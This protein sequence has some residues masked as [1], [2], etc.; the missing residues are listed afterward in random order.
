[1]DGRSFAAE[2]SAGRQP[3][4][5][6]IFAEIASDAAIYKGQFVP[7]QF[8]AHIMVRNE[9]WKYV[10]NRY[11]AGEL[12]HL[13]ADPSEMNNLALDTSHRNR[14]ND[15]K[16]LITDMLR[17]TGPGIYEWCLRNER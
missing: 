14:I 7:E 16:R 9:G 13:D 3:E 12:Y 8:A 17:K 10:W 15:M 6:P 11:D 2:I 4:S 5:G 1:M